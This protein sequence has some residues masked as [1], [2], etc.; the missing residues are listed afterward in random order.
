LATICCIFEL[1]FTIKQFFR[2]FFASEGETF[3]AWDKKGGRYMSL[4]KLFIIMSCLVATS[5]FAQQD[6]SK[7]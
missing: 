3:I 7:V 4:K 1:L 6:F 5:A 2:R